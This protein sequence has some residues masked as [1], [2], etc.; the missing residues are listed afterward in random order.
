M[1][2]LITFLLLIGIS[3]VVF[4]ELKPKD[5]AGKWK[6]AVVTDQGDM[7]GNLVFKE[8]E[9]KLTGEVVTNDSGTFAMDKVELKD[10]NVLYFELTPDYEP[11]KVTVK[12]EG[13]KFKGT[14]ATTQGEFNLT[15]EKVE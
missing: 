10:G 11:I 3:T 6:Y 7:T 14:G 13:K 4:A 15:G 9:G 1:K 2:K 5:V 8:T 12:V